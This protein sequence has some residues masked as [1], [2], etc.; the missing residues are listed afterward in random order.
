M[1][2]KSDIRLDAL[3]ELYYDVRSRRWRYKDTKAFAPMAAV[4]SQAEKYRNAKQLE[5][6][7]LGAKF[8]RGELPVKEF[9]KQAA[10]AIKQIHLAEMIRALDKQ[11]QATGDRF[12][13]VARNLR[14]QYYSG[15]DTLTK[16]RYGLKY[17]FKDLVEGRVSPGQLDNRLRLF[18]E[19]GKVTY[20]GTRR[21]IASNNFT[22]VRR[23][24]GASEHCANCIE[25]ARRGWDAIANVI[26]PT[27]ACQCR[28]NCKCS[29][30]FR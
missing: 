6:V 23:R 22:E 21:D 17:L 15:I 2:V 24:L 27:Q 30:E 9:Q 1:L 25:Y 12:L 20:W 26:L 5:L 19:S 14:Q 11:E 8:T 28:T 16:E 10:I 13:L 3:P 18:S 4:K 7:Q 29:L